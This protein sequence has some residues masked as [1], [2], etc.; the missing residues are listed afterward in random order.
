MDFSASANTFHAMLAAV[1]DAGTQT[2]MA[3]ADAAVDLG[4]SRPQDVKLPEIMD[5]FSA[6]P[7][8]YRDR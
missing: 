7:P 8:L 5:D 6:T 2:S 3:A 4:V 1:D